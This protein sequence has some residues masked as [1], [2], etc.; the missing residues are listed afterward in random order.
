MFFVCARRAKTALMQ[1]INATEK[2]SYLFAYC[3]LFCPYLHKDK[4]TKQIT[5]FGLFGTAF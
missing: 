5:A 2:V 1:C 3:A 4:A